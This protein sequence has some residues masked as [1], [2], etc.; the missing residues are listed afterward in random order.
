[1][2]AADY[3]YV[4]KA[5]IAVGSN[6]FLLVLFNIPYSEG[7]VLQPCED[8]NLLLLLLSPFC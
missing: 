5:A 2:S 1:M 6:I 8:I 4:D 3:D 7:F